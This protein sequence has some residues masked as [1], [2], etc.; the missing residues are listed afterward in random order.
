[1]KTLPFLLRGAKR[2]ACLGLFVCA[3]AAR[4][5][6]L[7]TQVNM[8]P[9]AEA[10]IRLIVPGKAA[11]QNGFMP[12][13]VRINNRSRGEGTWKL[14]LDLSRG[15]GGSAQATTAF[16]FTVPG[17]ER[18]EFVVFAASAGLP[19][20]SGPV[21]MAAAGRVSGPG[22]G[23]DG[24]FLS[25]T[26][27][28]RA[29]HAVATEPALERAFSKWFPEQTG[30]RAPAPTLR[31]SPRV[32][33]PT[34]VSVAPGAQATAHDKLAVFDPAAWP[35]D[36]RMWSAFA[37]V[38]LT[39]E[40]WANLDEARR[41]ALRDRIAMGARLVLV[42]AA[43][44]GE[45]KRERFGAGEIVT[46]DG[47]LGDVTPSRPGFDSPHQLSTEALA[48]GGFW[49]SIAEVV[50]PPPR[51]GWLTAF[52]IVFGLAVGPVNLFLFA[53][54]GKRHRLFFTVPVI[55][56][57]ATVVLFG[58]IFFSDGLGGRGS[59]RTLVLLLPERNEA[60]VVQRQYSRTGLLGSR[61]FALPSDVLFE[62]QPEAMVLGGSQQLWREGD[63]ASGDW[64]VSRGE[65]RHALRRLAPTRER[66][67][68]S[69]EPDGGFVVQSTVAARLR[70][71]AYRDE[72]L[73]YW[74]APEVAPG[75]R[76]KLERYAGDTPPNLK[77][78]APRVW[79][80]GAFYAVADAAPTVVIATLPSIRWEDDRVLYT[81]QLAAKEEVKP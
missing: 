27:G 73:T 76:V 6:D 8:A 12:V 26:M 56:L 64:F 65:Q 52:V 69:R 32:P 23:R 77:Q 78:Q 46:L 60:V 30:P 40:T 41:N 13:R 72:Q 3:L 37:I 17:G 38:A 21:G 11:Y 61:K 1:M 5:A 18:R 70:D 4:A 43:A 66:V 81:G 20:I 29:P 75:Q 39:Q 9:G 49:G 57:A 35:A 22:V 7:E 15:A 55:S 16:S 28:W 14:E 67:E 58:A 33:L 45:F 79:P 2:F 25:Q 74:I 47:P 44:G 62:R 80:A 19:R 51:T 53:P 31:R 68:L 54:A 10:D 24:V 42:P 59:R 71:F 63:T 48:G 36:W 50:P 34:G